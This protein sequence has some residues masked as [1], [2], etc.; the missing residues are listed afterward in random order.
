MA[1][2]ILAVGLILAERPAHPAPLPARG[3]RE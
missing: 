1:L 2:Q 3:E